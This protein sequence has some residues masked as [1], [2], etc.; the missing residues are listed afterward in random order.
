MKLQ[1]IDGDDL[2]QVITYMYILKAK[3]G[4][5][6]APL[7]YHPQNQFPRVKDLV[8]YDGKMGIY[9][10]TV[11]TPANRFKDYCL[12]MEQYEKELSDILLII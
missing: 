6:I 2:H 12:Q 9:G 1:S 7:S 5:V 11:D 3:H 8:G 4:G 10:V